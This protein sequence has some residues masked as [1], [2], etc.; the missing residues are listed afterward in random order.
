M[1][2]S[3]L[4]NTSHSYSYISPAHFSLLQGIFFQA[5]LILF[6]TDI[7]IELVLTEA[8]SPFGKVVQVKR[9]WIYVTFEREEEAQNA[10][11]NRNGKMVDQRVIFVD[12]A[13][14]YTRGV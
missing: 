7:F 8:F 6:D 5:F 13:G 10:L 4:R 2:N 12:K 3:F 1:S 14:G 9:I 11:T